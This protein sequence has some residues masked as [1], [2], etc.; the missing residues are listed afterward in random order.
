MPRMEV[1]KGQ[2]MFGGANP[3]I[4][5]ARSQI[6]KGTF[7]TSDPPIIRRA[8]PDDLAH[9]QSAADEADRLASPALAEIQ[10]RIDRARKQLDVL[11]AFLRRR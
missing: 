5:N 4:E 7:L 9:F 6:R 2:A 10:A 1:R 11:R 8:L 3:A